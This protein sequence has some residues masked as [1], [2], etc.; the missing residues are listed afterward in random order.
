MK[1][2]VHA[3]KSLGSALFAKIYVTVDISLAIAP[4]LRTRE[5]IRVEPDIRRHIAS[6]LRRCDDTRF[7]YAKITSQPI[8]HFSLRVGRFEIEESLLAIQ[9]NMIAFVAIVETVH[10]NLPLERDKAIGDQFFVKP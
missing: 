4:N 9:V 2:R 7:I 1:F 3:G 8:C 6:D 10:G 5:A